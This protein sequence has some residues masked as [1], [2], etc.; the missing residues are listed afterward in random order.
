MKSFSTKL[1][2]VACTT[3]ISIA[4]QA[5]GADKKVAQMTPE[6]KAITDAYMKAAT[7]G[8]EHK[9]L[10]QDVGTWKVTVKEFDPA[11]NV[12]ESKARSVLKSVLGGRFV[13]EQ[14]TGTMMGG[15]KFEGRGFYGY[16]NVQK[17]Y[18]SS[19]SDN[20]G[21]GI[22]LTTGTW[23]EP[24]KTFTATGSFMDPV[25]HQMKSMKM[26]TRTQAKNKKTTEF[27]DIKPDGTSFKMMEMTYTR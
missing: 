25:S 3:L 4:S 20:M 14:F 11:G 13:E 1:L 22:M 9:M 17:K 24:S 7:P 10:M 16:D 8:P 19:W 26:V 2:V 5:S 6:E 23:D 27:Y 12:Q 15:V 21:T 18:V